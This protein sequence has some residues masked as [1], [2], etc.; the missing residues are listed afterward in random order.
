[1]AR[2]RSVAAGRASWHTTSAGAP[3]AVLLQRYLI[4][5]VRHHVA[6]SGTRQQV[7]RRPQPPRPGASKEPR[8][9][10][11]RRRAE[12]LLDVQWGVRLRDRAVGSSAPAEPLG[13]VR[14]ANLCQT[15][16]GRLGLIIPIT[17]TPG[18]D[19]ESREFSPPRRAQT[20]EHHH[21]E[22]RRSRAR[23]GN[24]IDASF[25]W[26]ADVDE[27]PE[28]NTRRA[29]AADPVPRATSVPPQSERRSMQSRGAH[30]ANSHQ[31]CNGRN[32]PRRARGA[33]SLPHRLL[34]NA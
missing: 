18:N 7:T 17:R 5:S 26:G 24:G 34:I 11:W 10:M 20:S 4:L 15:C 31:T 3:N 8:S 23:R 16:P 2:G 22:R 1:M 32:N 13:E 30:D 27:P 28:V 21:G 12:R 9:A 29:I 25:E 19:I 33:A 6:A 14:P